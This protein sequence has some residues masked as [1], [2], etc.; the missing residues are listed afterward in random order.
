MEIDI[1]DYQIESDNFIKSKEISINS[2]VLKENQIKVMTEVYR[3]KI[4][5]EFESLAKE[6]DKVKEAKADVIINE[7]YNSESFGEVERVYLHL[8]V[9]EKKSTIKPILSVKKIEIGKDKKLENEEVAY[10]KG[11]TEIEKQLKEKIHELFKIQ[12][13]NIIISF[14]E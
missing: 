5:A 7:D 14:L 13:E 9:D 2:D 6:I 10:D 12:K 11:D 8:A 1:E 4:I 3:E